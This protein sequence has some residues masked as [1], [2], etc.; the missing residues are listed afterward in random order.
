MLRLWAHEN[1]ISLYNLPF[2]HNCHTL[3]IA[4]PFAHTWLETSRRKPMQSELA[5][6]LKIVHRLRNPPSHISAMS[7]AEYNDLR[8]ILL[9]RAILPRYFS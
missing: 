7:E 4:V 5:E 8:E 2:R 1:G 9:I 6:A 3:P